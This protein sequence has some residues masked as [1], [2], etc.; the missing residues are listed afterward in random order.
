MLF[1]FTREVYH[2]P[3]AHVPRLLAVVA[4]RARLSC[5]FL[6]R[7]LDVVA[8]RLPRTGLHHREWTNGLLEPPRHEPLGKQDAPHAGQN[9]SRA[10]QGGWHARRRLVGRP[11]VE[12]QPGVRRLSLRDAQAPRGRAAA[13]A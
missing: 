2:A 7:P 8:A 1:T 12:R 11:A 3:R 4:A 10:R 13:I 9:G 6:R 5:T